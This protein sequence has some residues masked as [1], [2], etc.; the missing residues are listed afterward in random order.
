MTL[1]VIQ[2]VPTFDRVSLLLI[3]IRHFLELSTQ[4]P[5]H[6][7]PSY[8]SLDPLFERP[9]SL[10]SSVLEPTLTLLYHH[11]KILVTSHGHCWNNGPGTVLYGRPQL[12]TSR[13]LLLLL[14]LSQSAFHCFHGELTVNW[15]LLLSPLFFML[16]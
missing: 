3:Y 11:S 14:L 8:C 10:Y 1:R 15:Q 13:R 9:G 16:S 5:H 4:Q 12:L 2:N 7:L 6:R